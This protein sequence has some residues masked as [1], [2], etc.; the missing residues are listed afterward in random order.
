MSSSAIYL[1]LQPYGDSDLG[2]TLSRGR[3]REEKSAQMGLGRRCV[4]T[5]THGVRGLVRHCCHRFRGSIRRSAES[6]LG[7][8]IEMLLK[9]SSAFTK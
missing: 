7:Y 6:D 9:C 8:G 2:A 4:R 5:G 1:L 3:G